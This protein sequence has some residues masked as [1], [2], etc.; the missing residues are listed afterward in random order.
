MAFLAPWRFKLHVGGSVGRPHEAHPEDETT[1]PFRSAPHNLEPVTDRLITV[2][3]NGLRWNRVTHLYCL[4]AGALCPQAVLL[5][6]FGY[7]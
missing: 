7:R 3:P 4:V 6:S 1:T 2:K 5:E